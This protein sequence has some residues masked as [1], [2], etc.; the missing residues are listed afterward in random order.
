MKTFFAEL[1][2]RSE[3]LFYLGV[4]CL[5]LAVTFFVLASVSTTQVL[6]INA[7]IKPLKFALSITIY[8]WTM[9]WLITYLP[10]FNKSLFGWTAIVLLGFEIVYI[11]LQAGRGQLSHFN[12]STPLYQTLYMVMAAAITVVVIYTAYIGVLFFKNKFPQ[13]PMHYVWAIRLGI[14]LF[15]IFSFEGFIMGNKLS[16]TV[17]GADGSIGLPFVNWSVKYGDLRIA[18]FVGM[19]ALQIL[20]L[21]SFYVL[22][23]SFLTIAVAF[24]YA[25]GAASVL[26]IALIGKPLVALA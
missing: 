26:I 18:H 8:S 6:G 7:W 5:A 19:H 25:G 23:N 16:H 12:V 11:A 17:G 22:R 21:L 2:N 9:G 15:V 10:N 13:L 4:V 14:L 20:P 1:K 24:L 3:H